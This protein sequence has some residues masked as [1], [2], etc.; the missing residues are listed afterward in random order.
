MSVKYVCRICTYDMLCPEPKEIPI[1]PKIWQHIPFIKLTLYE[2]IPFLF[3]IKPCRNKIINIKYF[4]ILVN[5]DVRV[6]QQ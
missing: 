1:N 5:F 2:K 4:S 3:Y 6:I